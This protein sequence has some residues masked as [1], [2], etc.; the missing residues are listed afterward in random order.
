MN[1][2]IQLYSILIYISVP[3]FVYAN[4]NSVIK[5]IVYPT[6]AFQRGELALKGFFNCFLVK[7]EK[8]QKEKK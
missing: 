1:I 8:K 3:L 6:N 4:N 5:D 2:I 7:G